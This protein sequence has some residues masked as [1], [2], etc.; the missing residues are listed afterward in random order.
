VRDHDGVDEDLDVAR[1]QAAK[2]RPG[3]AI[4]NMDDVDAGG[5]AKRFGQDMNGRALTR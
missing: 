4:G 1:E 5:V 3:A 2:R